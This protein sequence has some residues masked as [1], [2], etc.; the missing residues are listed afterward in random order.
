MWGAQLD[1]QLGDR[2]AACAASGMLNLALLSGASLASAFLPTLLPPEWRGQ[3][4]VV[5]QPQSDGET[6]ICTDDWL[7]R[8]WQQLARLPDLSALAEWPLV[9]LQ[10]KRLCQG[11]DA[12]QVSSASI[13]KL[14]Y[15]LHLFNDLLKCWHSQMP[16][17]ILKTF[18]LLAC[19]GMADVASQFANTCANCFDK[20]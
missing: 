14:P 11:I 3:R 9:P 19:I 16:S 1:S 4:E 18:A 10:G 6:S 5:W 15:A 13:A 2:L 7:S 12:A 17:C 20:W 8:L